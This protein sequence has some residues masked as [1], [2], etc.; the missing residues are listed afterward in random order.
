MLQAGDL[1]L[2]ADDLLCTSSYPLDPNDVT[3]SRVGRQA[4]RNANEPIGY[5]LLRNV[6]TGRTYI[7]TEIQP[8][9]DFRR[10]HQVKSSVFCLEIAEEAEESIWHRSGRSCPLYPVARESLRNW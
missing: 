7:R 8:Y 4:E 5:F 2:G 10:G 3:P 1:M 9:W 6:H